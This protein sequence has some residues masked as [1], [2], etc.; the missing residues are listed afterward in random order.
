MGNCEICG[1]LCGVMSGGREP[2][3][4]NN[5]YVCNECGAILKQINAEKYDAAKCMQ[6]A[7]NL[8]GLC[9][10]DED[11]RAIKDFVNDVCIKID[12]NVAYK[13]KLDEYEKNVAEIKKNYIEY[14][15]NFK[16]TTGYDFDGYKIIE[17]KGI[18]SGEVVLGTGFISEFSASFSDFFGTKS[19]MFAE[20][21][22]SAKKEAQ[23]RLLKN[24][25]KEGAN[26]LIG[27]DFDYIT[28]DNNVLGIS[29]NG[30][31]VVIEKQENI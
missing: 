11:I 22:R 26:A 27:V 21:M 25:M 24:A 28:F 8:I 14:V 30:T 23:D 15:K 16:Y 29:A 13:E 20:K 10:N 2:F 12:E 3:T 6:L 18:V 19:S 17:Y 5:M 9:S 31:A 4:Q 1:K 7:K